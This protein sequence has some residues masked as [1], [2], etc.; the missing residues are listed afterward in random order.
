MKLKQRV[1]KKLKLAG[2]GEI[3]TGTQKSS[4]GHRH[5]WPGES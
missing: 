4:I 1:I 3:I 2:K 5:V